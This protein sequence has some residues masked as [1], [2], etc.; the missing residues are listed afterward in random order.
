MR[1]V[2]V[3]PPTYPTHGPTI[4]QPAT[5]PFAPMEFSPP[6]S[7]EPN[8][9]S[10]IPKPPSPQSHRQPAARPPSRERSPLNRDS[11]RFLEPKEYHKLQERI[12]GYG[13]IT[14]YG[15]RCS[16]LRSF[17]GRH[18][19]FFFNDVVK[20]RNKNGPRKALGDGSIVFFEANRSMARFNLHAYFD[21]TRV[22]ILS[23]NEEERLR[24]KHGCDYF[25][26]YN[27][28]PHRSSSSSTAS[29]GES[30][31]GKNRRPLLLAPESTFGRHSTS[32]HSSRSRSK[33]RS[34]RWDQKERDLRERIPK[35]VEHQV[36]KERDLRERIP[37]SV[38]P[39]PF[40]VDKRPFDP[41]IVE[42]VQFD[43]KP[44]DFGQIDGSRLENEKK[45]DLEVVV[46]GDS[47]KCVVRDAIEPSDDP[48]LDE[49]M[50]YEENLAK[51]YEFDDD[52][53]DDV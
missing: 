6:Q 45:Q 11:R 46:E 43:S 10:P 47:R 40:V 28:R 36:V 9:I 22:D 1:P 52:E 31:H 32:A 17:V 39:Q 27:D 53:N 49:I 3:S 18:K 48:D 34:S 38:K 33:E 4:S 8:I 20:D 42:K 30:D 13:Q 35:M 19:V 5:H 24:A 15:P 7:P 12:S 25:K 14:Y 50:T 44:A 51:K 16:F 2:T 23:S 41:S 29:S 37:K 26:D 21:A